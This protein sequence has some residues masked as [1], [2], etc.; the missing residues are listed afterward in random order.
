[1]RFHLNLTK[2]TFRIP[3]PFRRRENAA[4]TPAESGGFRV[5]GA[6]R[7]QQGID[8]PEGWSAPR[9][10]RVLTVTNPD[11]VSPEPPATGTHAPNAS[12]AGTGEAAPPAHPTSPASPTSPTR[13]SVERHDSDSSDSSFEYNP[14]W[15]FHAGDSPLTNAGR[16][17]SLHVVNG[18]PSS[19]GSSSP[20]RPAT[21]D[22]RS[23]SPETPAV[24]RDRFD[25]FD[26]RAFPPP[27]GFRPLTRHSAM[28][29][30]PEQAEAFRLAAIGRTLE[31][32]SAPA[33][34]HVRNRPQTP[35]A[36]E[37]PDPETIGIAL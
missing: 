15:I 29:L 28:R 2:P 6:R 24:P 31:R 11:R 5:L 16:Y 23:P 36:Q 30:H 22:S 35:P 19:S 33:P 27:G 8:A 3:N 17:G 32:P 21:R 4:A 25:D 7:E 14:Q 20:E 37:G 13:P 18:S 10:S 26:P 34:D 1:M 9:E 12:A